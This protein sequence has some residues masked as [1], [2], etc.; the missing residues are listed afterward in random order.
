VSFSLSK[1]PYLTAS[2]TYAE[3]RAMAGDSFSQLYRFIDATSATDMKW[4]QIGYEFT[5]GSAVT[6]L[7]FES[8]YP[9]ASTSGGI[10]ASGPALDNVAVVEKQTIEHFIKGDNGDSLDFSGLM[11]SVGAPETAEDIFSGGWLDFD[12]SSGTDTSIGFDS[13]GG[14]DNYVEIITLVGTVLTE[15]DTGNFV[16]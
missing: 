14:G 16:V 11:D 5:A 8:T 4:Q 1:N 6:E 2:D 15:S 7:K 12:S 10:Y 13:N 3:V 9:D